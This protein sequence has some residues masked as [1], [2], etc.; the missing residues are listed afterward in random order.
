MAHAKLHVEEHQ[1]SRHWKFWSEGLLLLGL[2]VVLLWFDRGIALL[3]PIVGPPVSNVQL[4]NLQELFLQHLTI[5]AIATTASFLMAFG[6]ASIV[7]ITR[8][9]SLKSNLLSLCG[10]GETFPTAAI[11]ALLV[12]LMGYGMESVVIALFIYGLMPIF[13]NTI[14]GLESVPKQISEAADGM[15]LTPLQKYFTVELKLGRPFVL[16]GV[17][18]SLIVNIAAATIG[19]VVGAGGLGM[20]IMSGIRIYDPILIM[21]GALPL[22]LL[23]LLV[24]GLFRKLEKQVY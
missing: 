18:L 24:D 4:W 6:L 11:I 15:G 16:G 3:E 1:E 19:A 22:I 23:A 2:I 13:T 8:F 14:Q 12:P 20:P 5:V 17:R 9:E 7:H 21:K 10:F